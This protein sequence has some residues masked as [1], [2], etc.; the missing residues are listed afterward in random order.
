MVPTIYKTERPPIWREVSFLYIEP[1][2][3]GYT[4]KRSHHSGGQT[5][6][7]MFS[8]ENIEIMKIRSIIE[9]MEIVKINEILEI[10]KI[11]EIIEK[12]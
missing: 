7:G 2:Q 10:M 12:V 11:I 9:I 3:R 4:Q 6:V 8:V 5:L 1:I